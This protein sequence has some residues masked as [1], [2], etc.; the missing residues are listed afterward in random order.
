MQTFNIGG[1]PL[2]AGIH[3]E[4]TRGLRWL[5]Y[6]DMGVG[7]TTLAATANDAPQMAP[8]LFIN[9]DDGL[10][11]VDWRG[12]VR[13]VRVTN[14]DELRAAAEILLS[15]E[16]SRPEIFQGVRTVVVDSLSALRSRVIREQAKADF[17]MHKVQDEY[18]VTQ[19]AW[20]RM[21]TIITS[22]S[23]R[24][25]Q[26][27]YHMVFTAGANIVQN[28]LGAVTSV[29]PDLN[30][31]LLKDFGHMVDAVMVLVVTG[32]QYYLR[33]L[34]LDPYLTKVRNAAFVEAL[35][36][37]TRAQVAGTET[38]PASAEGWLKNPSFKTLCELYYGA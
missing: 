32:G 11:S 10:T 31:A 14:V 13:Q 24:L 34:P 27:G 20:G 3:D 29:R 21:T 5:I 12:D 26:A 7:K 6:G 35:R 2:R 1:V 17:L 18:T 25:A 23:D 16:S 30:P 38:D 15:P 33:C 37:Y 19:R 9:V 36:K 8:A 22:L 4:N 28:E